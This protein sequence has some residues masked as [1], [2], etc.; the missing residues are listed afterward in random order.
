MFKVPYPYNT[1]TP[2]FDPTAKFGVCQSFLDIKDSTPASKRGEHI[3]DIMDDVYTG[4]R[5]ATIF[6]RYETDALPNIKGNHQDSTTDL[7]LSLQEALQDISTL[8]HGCDVQQK[9]YLVS[10]LGSWHSFRFVFL[11]CFLFCFCFFFTSVSPL[12]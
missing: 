7:P 4:R 6:E 10:S 5:D 8:V 12:V 9:Q 3:V 1:T 11:C 2:K